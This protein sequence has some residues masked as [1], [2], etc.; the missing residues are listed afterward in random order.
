MAGKQAATSSEPVEYLDEPPDIGDLELYTVRT[1]EMVEFSFQI[2]GPGSRLLAWVIDTV[3]FI[4]IVL[5]MAVIFA[6]VGCGISTNLFNVGGYFLALFMILFALLQLFYMT[7][8][9]VRWNGQTPGKRALGLRVIGENGLRLTFQQSIIRN[10][11]RA[12]DSQPG[13]WF[14]PSYIL[15]MLF[16]L[17]SENAQ[18]IGDMLA[19]TLVIREE[20]RLPPER[21]KLPQAKYNS[22]LRDK[23]FALRCTK[24]LKPEE[25]ELLLEVVQRRDELS[26]DARTRL[27]AVLSE[28]FQDRLLTSGHEQHLSHE[29]WI[30]NLAQALLEGEK[31]TLAV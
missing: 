25:R 28:Y 4:G 17:G 5:V 7:F 1:P 3:I 21:L 11:V 29:K 24:V 31:Q 8:F 18:R 30:L 16:L 14:I 26:L 12:L 6:I 19:G 13:L 27:F 23:T 20:K 9:E 22:L 10:F 2:A 15:G